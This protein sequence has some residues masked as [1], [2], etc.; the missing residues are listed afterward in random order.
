VKL[1]KFLKDDLIHAFR[2]QMELSNVIS[3]KFIGGKI[4]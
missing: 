3:D 4:E 2:I 1:R